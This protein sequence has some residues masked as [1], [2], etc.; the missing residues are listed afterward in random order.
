MHKSEEMCKILEKEMDKIADK[1]TIN[2]ADLDHVF[3]ISDSLKN[4]ATYDA[5][6]ESG[7]SEGAYPYYYMD[8]G[9]SYARGRRRD[10]MGRYAR[11]DGYM[12]GRRDRDGDGRYYEDYRYSNEGESMRER[13]EHMMRDA[14]T[15]QE[16]NALRQAMNQM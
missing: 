6:K 16:R 14:K 9:N 11:D 13:L 10:S 12:Y 1:G 3:K 5:M 8:G 4:I 15:E 7:Y 2:E